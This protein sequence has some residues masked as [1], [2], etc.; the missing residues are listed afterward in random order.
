MSEQPSRYLRI[1]RPVSEVELE[2]LKAKW[3]ENHPGQVVVLPQPDPDFPDAGRPEREPRRARRRRR[4]EQ[5]H[6]RLAREIAVLE[7]E[8]GIA[9][10]EEPCTHW[11][12]MEP[13]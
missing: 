8:L 12:K 7:C 13:L 4:A 3:R 11:L 1:D 6:Q 9:C 2:Q 5:R 10:D